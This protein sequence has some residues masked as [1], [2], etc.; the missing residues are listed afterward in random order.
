MTTE[1]LNRTLVAIE[2]APHHAA[3]LRAEWQ[4][5]AELRAHFD[6]ESVFLAWHRNKHRCVHLGGNVVRAAGAE[7]L[8]GGLKSLGYRNVQGT[9]WQSYEDQIGQLWYPRVATTVTTDQAMEVHKWLSSVPNPTKWTGERKPQKLTDFGITVIGEKYELTIPVDVD[10]LRRDKTGQI[11]ANVGDMGAR[12][13]ALPQELAIAALEANGVAFDG[14]SLFNASHSVLQSGTQ[15]NE[16]SVTGLANPDAPTSAEM[17]RAIL[18]MVTQLRMLKNERGQPANP[19]ARK[20]VLLYPTKYLAAVTAAL[21]DMF[22]SAGTS[23][24]LVGAGLE[25]TAFDDARFAGGANAAGRKLMLFR[26][27]A[28][29]RGLIFQDEA[30]PDALKTQDADSEMGF[31]QDS[32]AWG[33]KRICAAAPGQ[34]VLAVRATLTT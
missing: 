3:T 12:M 4:Q 20:F 27:D 9:Y 32:V 28:R 11:L 22:T 13:A 24:T 14:L 26:E 2:R 1:T 34:F 16:I 7:Q 19:S 25:I 15:S 33:S 8:A 29:I 10:D 6:S 5:S 23:N 30:L 21:N 17:V 18:A 31:W